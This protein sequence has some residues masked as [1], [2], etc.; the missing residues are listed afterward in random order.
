VFCFSPVTMRAVPTTGTPLLPRSADSSRMRA[1]SAGDGGQ[2]GSDFSGLRSEARGSTRSC[3]GAP[4][5]LVNRQ[6]NANDQSMGLPVMQRQLAA[7]RQH[8]GAR[9]RKP[10]APR[11]NSTAAFGCSA[12]TIS[13]SVRRSICTASNFA[14]CCRKRRRA[15]E[16]SFDST[17]AAPVL[18]SARRDAEICRRQTAASTIP[19][20][21]ISTR[22][23]Q[24][25]FIVVMAM[26]TSPNA[27]ARYVVVGGGL[28]L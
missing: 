13:E 7:M 5:R 17:R 26:A 15:H 23:A 25:Q 6:L 8:D 14:P 3:G 4:V 22:V 10:E 19:R 1:P 16:A 12:A 21:S 9:D 28:E 2:S 27:T 18:R 24:Q 11:T 20:T